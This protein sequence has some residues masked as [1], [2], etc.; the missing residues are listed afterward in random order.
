MHWVSGMRTILHSDMN[1]FYAS[2]ECV[3]HPELLD[4]PVVVGGDPELRHG[5]VLAKNMLAKATGIKTGEALWIARQKCPGLTVVPAHYPL[6]LRY[7]QLARKIYADY[8][9]RVE[10]FGLDEAWLDVTGCPGGDGETIAQEIRRRIREELKVTVSVGVS[11]NKV[12]AKLGS[13]M[14]KP[15]AVTVI[16][17]ENY[18]QVVWPLPVSDLLYVGPATQE[19][20]RMSNILSIG[21]LARCD[22]G[23]LR[24]KFGKS[25]PALAAFARGQDESPVSAEGCESMLKSVGN[26]T[27]T[28]RDL[29]SDEDARIIL[30]ALADSVAARLREHGLRCTTVSISVRDNK[31][32]TF[33]RQVRL[34]APTC[35][36]GEIAAAAME[37]FR[38]NY[39]WPRPVRSLGVCG[40]DLVPVSAPQQLDLFGTEEKRMRRERLE[41]AVDGVHHR[42][43]QSSLLRASAMMDPSLSA[44]EPRREHLVTPF[45]SLSSVMVSHE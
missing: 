41:R 23:M 21:D 12:F 19:K 22:D 40:S 3:H 9:D 28:P 27:T 39:R 7:A 11:Y 36:A 24:A 32:M 26:S 35:I 38:A 37:L 1:N 14:K 42:F 30:Y 15:D 5:I 18:R 16:S 44:D 17:R 43:G 31:L 25:G 33:T 10:P 13:D 34:K 4:K 2:V 29:T 8:T 45:D 6:Y 20:L